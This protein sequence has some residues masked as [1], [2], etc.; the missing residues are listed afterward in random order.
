VQTAIVSA[1]VLALFAAVDLWFFRREGLPKRTTKTSGAI[2]IRGLVNFV[3]IAM[4]IAAILLSAGS[5]N[6]A[7]LFDVFGTPAAL[8]NLVRDA[9]LIGI[10]LL[11]LWL[12]PN[13]HRASNGFTWEPIREVAILFAGIFT[14]IIPCSPCCRPAAD[15]AFAF[16][17]TAVTATTDCRTRPPISG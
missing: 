7:R 10:A 4:I 15:G 8:Q 9:A 13:E 17:L 3:L 16:L 1:F 2:R 5:G 12:T 11:S 6:R 14:A